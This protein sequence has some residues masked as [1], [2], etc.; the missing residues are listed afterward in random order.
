MSEATTVTG[1]PQLALNI[2]GTTVY[3]NYASGSGTAALVYSYTILSSQTDANGISIDANS[4]SLNGGTL[5]DAA[6]N[7]ATLTHSAVTDNASYLVNN[8]SIELA[9][10]AAAIG[11]FVINGQAWDDNSGYSVSNAGDVNGDGLADLIVG[12]YLS[13]PSA[14]VNAGRSYV[15]FGKSGTTAVNLSDVASGTGGFVINGASSQDSSG[16]SVSSAGDI[17][18]DGLVDLIVGASGSNDPAL[19]AG[20]SY[21]VFGK[22]STSAVDLSTVV[23]GTGGFVINGQDAFGYSGTSVSSA[24]DVNGDGLQDLIVGAYQSSP[25]AGYQA[26]RSYVVFGKSGT[27]AVNLSDVASSIGGFV[28]NGQAAGDYSGGSVSS[29]GDVNGDGLADLIVGAYNSDPAAGVNAGRSYVVFGKADTSAV[30]LSSVASGSGGFVINGQAAGDT[31][32]SSVSGAGDVNG[33]GLAD[34][35][36]GA[37][38]SDPAA[39]LSAGRSYVV[40]GKADTSAVDLSSVASGSGGFVIKGQ[41][42]VEHSGYSVSNA[43]DINGDGLADLIVGARWSHTTSGGFAGRTYIVY[44]KSGTTEVNLSDVALGTG[45]FV[46]NGQ[47][48]HDYSGSSVSGAGDVNGDGLADLIVGAPSHDPSGVTTAGRSYV[49]FGSNSGAFQQSTVDQLGTTGADTLT[50][51]TASETLVGGAGNDIL[52]GNGG[53][54]VLFGGAGNDTIYINASNI[55]ALVN[56]LGTGD[57]IGQLARVDGGGGYDTLVLDG[58]GI[59]LD[60]SSIANQG[61]SD[62]ESTSRVESIEIIQLSSS[63]SEI[64]TL[65]LTLNDVLDM[66]GMNLFN[67]LTGITDGTYDLAAGGADGTNPEAKHQLLIDG[68]SGSTV[69]STGWGSSVGTVV[70]SGS[71]ITYNVYNQGLYA[72]LLINSNLTVLV[73]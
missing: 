22:T 7:A 36:V 16:G 39:G 48:E 67:N 26:G 25:S 71:G 11:G 57:N 20:R 17:N 66:S 29:A 51:T 32:G 14:G 72:Q 19:D 56:P 65:T 60:L 38:Q 2:G 40:F 59:S 55:A 62:P 53:A 37:Y 42:I 45:G 47:A 41:S 10:I 73:A 23:V 52:Y 13:D 12:A 27:T 49:I 50:G 15:V 30:D 64:N 6:G 61:G 34:L 70:D 33:D 4:L 21:V 1:T 9:D 44:G 3:A 54:D 69:N 46:I 24:G 18:G 58:S 35:I 8:G 43:G 68:F 63:S 31:S 28:I 5:T